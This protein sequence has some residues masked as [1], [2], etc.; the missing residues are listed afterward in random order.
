MRATQVR[1]AFDI[2]NKRGLVELGPALDE[3]SPYERM[4]L[5]NEGSCRCTFPPI[6]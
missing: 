3:Q 4:W 6:A 1:H 2:L 5:G